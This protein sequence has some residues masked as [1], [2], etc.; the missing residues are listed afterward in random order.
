MAAT[1]CAPERGTPGIVL[2]SGPALDIKSPQPVPL[3]SAGAPWPN[4]DA[5]RPA[6]WRTGLA[7]AEVAD[8]LS[9]LAPRRGT[10]DPGRVAAWAARGVTLAT[11][12]GD[13]AL[14]RDC[15]ASQEWMWRL[16]EEIIGPPAVDSFWNA[17]S[18]THE[19]WSGVRLLDGTDGRDGFDPALWG[20]GTAYVNGPHSDN[21]R[22]MAC[23]AAHVRAGNRAAMIAPLDGCDWVQGATASV[24]GAVVVADFAS[25]NLIV[26]LGRARFRPPPGVTESSPR[27]AFQMGLWGVPADVVRDL[28]GARV[29][30]PEARREVVIVRGAGDAGRPVSEDRRKALAARDAGAAPHDAA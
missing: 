18:V 17:W 5:W 1:T 16:A 21:S 23:V 25:A 27:G 30:V 28:A 12:K 10:P 9:D 19:L 22:T 4:A 26:L 24:G 7:P 6:G 2:A 11:A 13:A 15:W 8:A 29:W 20:A 14:L 3:V